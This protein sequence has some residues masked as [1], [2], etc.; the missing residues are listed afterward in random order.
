LPAQE[1]GQRQT[2]L[3]IGLNL[4]GRQPETLAHIEV[5]ILPGVVSLLRLEQILLER[6]FGVDPNLAFR[7]VPDEDRIG[8]CLSKLRRDHHTATVINC[9]FVRSAKG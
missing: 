1:T 3:P 7:A 8:E 5:S 4:I 6:S 9:V 2:A